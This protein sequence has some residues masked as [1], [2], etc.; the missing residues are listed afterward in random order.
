MI[1]VGTLLRIEKNMAVIRMEARGGCR[2][3]AINTYCRQSGTGIR[4]LKLPMP[5]SRLNPG[6]LVEIDTPARSLVTA[7]FLVFIF[8][9]ILSISA[10][11]IIMTWSKNHGLAMAGFFGVFV[12]AELLV[13]VIDRRFGR[14]KFFQPQILRRIQSSK[15]PE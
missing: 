14:G 8:P 15:I 12:L 6:D 10:Y 2:S 13:V 4:E 3:C 1:E 5:K 11:G 7:A 9:L